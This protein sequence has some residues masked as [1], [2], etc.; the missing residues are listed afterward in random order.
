MTTQHA[1]IT[2]S[3][4]NGPTVIRRVLPALAI[5]LG[6]AG[7]FLAVQAYMRATTP[8]DQLEDGYRFQ[9][10]SGNWMM[11]NLGL[12]DMAPFGPL[13]LWLKHAYPPA[14]DAIRYVLMMPEWGNG[15]APDPVAVDLRLYVVYALL[16]G[17]T[18][19][20]AYVWVKDVTGNWRWGL[21]AALFWAIAP[22][23]IM[24]ATLL[25]PT[26]L[27]LISVSLS[28]YFLY[29][30]LRTRRPVYVPA[31]LAALLVASLA[32]SFIQIY[33]MVILVVA[34]VAFWFMTNN[35][36]RTWGWQV[37]NVV[38]LALIFAYPVKQFVMFDTW[39][40]T[41]FGGY[42][43]VG[44]LHLDPRN[45]E[46]ERSAASQTPADNWAAIEDQLATQSG[47]VFVPDAPQRIVDNAL[48][49]SSRFNTQELVKDNY[50]LEAA[51]N[52]YLRTNPL[53]SVQGLVK[54]LGI[55]IPEALKPTSVYTFNTIVERLPWRAP[56][57][58]LVSGWRLLALIGLAVVWTI[59]QRGWAGTWTLLKRYGW[60][61]LYF[62]LIALP[63]IFSNRYYPGREDEGPIWTDAVRQ[64][65]FLAMPVFVFVMAAAA[66][67]FKTL[68][69]RS[70]AA[71]RHNARSLD[72]RSP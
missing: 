2:T 29:R 59:W 66:D 52:Q 18:N 42:H 72:V 33:V 4:G 35:R 46:V 21:L 25:E 36:Y 44:M 54:S 61:G 24:A 32:R 22:G 41:T 70:K 16:Y 8:I 60:L 40:T 14:L 45:V 30:F 9:A 23:H 7:V 20:L 38:L 34:V 56:W 5:A 19:A 63:I 57:D 65:L 3:I 1:Q 43:R 71:R 48:I 6:S 68:R 39:S 27:S 55:T 47:T 62:I 67:F 53:A 49:F 10:W 37:L 31:F 69:H 11:Q 17:A 64:K 12:E 51:A 15:V 28:Y 50:R 26:Q 58:W 13:A